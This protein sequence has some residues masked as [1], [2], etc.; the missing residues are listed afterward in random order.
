MPIPTER[1]YMIQFIKMILI[2][3]ALAAIILLA[4]YY[5]ISKSLC[6]RIDSFSVADQKAMKLDASTCAK[7][8]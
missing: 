7:Y 3:V 5:A 6:S 2:S 8:Y 1:D 4:S